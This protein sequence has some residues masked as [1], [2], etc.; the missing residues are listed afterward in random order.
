MC[1]TK[2]KSVLIDLSGTLHIDNF[3]IPGSIHA[4]KRLSNHLIKI[5]LK[6]LLFQAQRIWFEI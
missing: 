2:I 5:I 3:A 1:S 6:N 4:L